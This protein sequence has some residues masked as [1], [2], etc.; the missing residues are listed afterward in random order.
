[1]SLPVSQWMV[2][3]AATRLAAL[4]LDRLAMAR[5]EAG[6]EIVEGRKILVV[7]VKLLVGALQEAVLGEKFPL[8]FARER[9]MR[10]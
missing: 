9:H 10:R 8:A 6:E 2:T 5:I 4:A 1:M 3:P 7:P